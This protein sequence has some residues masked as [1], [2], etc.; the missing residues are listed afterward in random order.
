ME[1]QPSD[2]VNGPL[3]TAKEL[4]RGHGPWICDFRQGEPA[5]AAADRKGLSQPV[6]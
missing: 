6:H 1:L 4:M 3:S 2:A 5:E